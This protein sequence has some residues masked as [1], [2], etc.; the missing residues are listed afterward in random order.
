[1]KTI[2]AYVTG[3][4]HGPISGTSQPQRGHVTHRTFRG[5]RRGI[6]D[7]GTHGRG[8]RRQRQRFGRICCGQYTES[9]D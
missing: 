8:H 4:P 9:R 3:R 5:R 6:V 7:I 1:M 2:A